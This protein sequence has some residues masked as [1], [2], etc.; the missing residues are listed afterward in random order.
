VSHGSDLERQKAVRVDDRFGNII[1]DD[2]VKKFRMTTVSAIQFP[3]GL[4]AKSPID[5][6][7]SRSKILSAATHLNNFLQNHV[8]ET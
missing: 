6:R 1:S 7:G 5:Q 4:N 8:I 3:F 2:M